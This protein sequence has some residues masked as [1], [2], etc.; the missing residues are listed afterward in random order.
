[1]EQGACDAAP[2]LG[3]PLPTDPVDAQ[4][5][6]SA[7]KHALAA[8]AAQNVDDMGRAEA[9][10]ALRQTRNAGHELPCLRA[11][12]LQ[13][14]RLA[15]IVAGSARSG[16]GF[17]QV[18]QLNRSAALGRLRVVQHLPQLLTCDALLFLEGRA[19]PRIDL[20]L[21]Q[22]FRRPYVGGPEIKGAARRVSVA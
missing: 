22:E 18:A 7:R 10:T 9:L 20:L 4:G 2:F 19:R 15:A 3:R 8:G 5:V 6:V 21:N 17:A 16:E 1:V 13:V 14:P 11:P 12:I